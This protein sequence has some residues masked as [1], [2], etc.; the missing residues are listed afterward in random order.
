MN[1]IRTAAYAVYLVAGTLIIATLALPTLLFGE[2]TARSAVKLWANAALFGLRLICGVRHRIEGAEHLPAGGA[3]VAANHQSMWETI[4]LFTI[5]EK[6]AITFKKE[7]RKVPVYGWWAMRAGCIPVDREAGAKAI[8]VLMKSARE[9]IEAGWQVVVFPEG[10]RAPPGERLPLQPGV[11]GIYGVAGIPCTPAIHD[12]GEFWRHP[13]G[14]TSLKI[15]GVIT[16]RILPPIP[17]GLNRKTF[18][19]ELES[20]LRA[21]ETGKA[22]E[23]P[24]TTMDLVAARRKAAR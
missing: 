5:L 18:L 14:V 15:P 19:R 24:P 20:R 23:V 6:P 4:A 2:R 3:L 12:S 8:R 22:P 16:L 21:G 13:G 1:R 17:A 9:R 10:T 7:L 11:A